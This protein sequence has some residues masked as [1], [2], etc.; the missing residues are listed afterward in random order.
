VL[1]GPRTLRRWRPSFLLAHA[2]SGWRRWRRD[3]L[4][5]AAVPVLLVAVVLAV[6]A[7]IDDGRIFL[8]VRGWSTARC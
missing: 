7:V 4:A 3:D 6:A 5:R 2:A 8:F 1:V